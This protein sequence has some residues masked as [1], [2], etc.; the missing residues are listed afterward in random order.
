[1]GLLC[2]ENPLGFWYVLCP[3]HFPS[4]PFVHPSYYHRI[5]YTGPWVFFLRTE[6]GARGCEFSQATY[7]IPANSSAAVQNQGVKIVKVRPIV[8]NP[9]K[10]TPSTPILYQNTFKARN[11]V[12]GSKSPLANLVPYSLSLGRYLRSNFGIQTH[13]RVVLFEP[14]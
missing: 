4:N 7:V 8:S 10:S 1:M 3:I 5:F 11:E 14:N 6:G 12:Q 9:K 13:S 2:G